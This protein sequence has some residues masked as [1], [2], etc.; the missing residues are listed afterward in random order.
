MLNFLWLRSLQK[1]YCCEHNNLALRGGGGELSITC[2]ICMGAKWNICTDITYRP[3][4]EI[5]P[6]LTQ[7]QNTMKP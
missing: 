3:R 6:S 7:T 5:R 1:I 2:E 4:K